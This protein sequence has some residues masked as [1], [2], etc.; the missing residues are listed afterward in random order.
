MVIGEA[1]GRSENT[2]VRIVYSAANSIQENGSPSTRATHP[3]L[4]VKASLAGHQRW[5]KGHCRTGAE[6]FRRSSFRSNLVRRQKAERE[7]KDRRRLLS[8]GSLIFVMALFKIVG[9]SAAGINL[10][11]AGV[12]EKDIEGDSPI[13]ISAAAKEIEREKQ[14][15]RDKSATEF[16]LVHIAIDL[17]RFFNSIS[18]LQLQ[19]N[20]PACAGK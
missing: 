7:T 3:T 8:H 13:I 18:W 14:L 5:Q 9:H 12:T 10:A 11:L 2:Q 1:R 4:C 16:V 17:L 19:M 15:G 20:S 6:S